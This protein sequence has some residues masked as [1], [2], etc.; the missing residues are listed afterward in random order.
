L[1]ATLSHRSLH[2]RAGVLALN[3]ALDAGSLHCCEID[4]QRRRAALRQPPD[5][6]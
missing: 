4:V 6:W 1:R 3:R 5:S 2:A